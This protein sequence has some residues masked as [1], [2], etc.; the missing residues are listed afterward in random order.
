VT[1]LADITLTK[2]GPRRSP[3]GAPIAWSIDVANAGPSVASDVVVTDS[4]PPG[5]GPMYHRADQGHLRP[6]RRVIT[7]ELGN[8]APGAS[9]AIQ[10]SGTVPAD[11]AATE[12]VN[13]A[14][15]TSPVAERAAPT[16]AG[17]RRSPPSR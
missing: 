3:P 16:T 13:A 10:L 12:L 5:L 6:R 15:V 1:P 11:T 7:C 9:A 14:A 2:N 17:P 8:V 4:L